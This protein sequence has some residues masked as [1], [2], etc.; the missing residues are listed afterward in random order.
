MFETLTLPAINR[1]LRSNS[2]AF[3]KLRPHAGKT[4]LVTCP[5][6]PRFCVMITIDGELAPAL[7]EAVPHVTIELTPGLLMRAAARDDSAWRDAR[8]SGDAEL[9]AAIDYVRSNIAWDYEESLS[10]VFGD[11]AAHRLAGAA[12]ELDRWGRGTL[13]NLAH[14]ASEY[15]TFESPL[16]A[17]AAE[18]ER[19]SREVDTIRDDAARLQK[20]IELL[21]KRLDART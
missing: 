21:G 17:S 20:R 6:G 16:L 15:A 4:V 12:R 2:W 5:P 8:V 3:G 11:V 1:L 10:R 18:I 14:A 19:W 9:A 13:R 7:P